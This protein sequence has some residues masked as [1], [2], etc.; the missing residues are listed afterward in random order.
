MVR[1]YANAKYRKNAVGIAGTSG[2]ST[3]LALRTAP[4]G[5]ASQL[6]KDPLLEQLAVSVNMSQL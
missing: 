1:S 6:R 2:M 3:M 4:V 5:A